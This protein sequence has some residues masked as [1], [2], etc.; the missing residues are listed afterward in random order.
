VFWFA[1]ALIGAGTGYLVATGAAADIGRAI[2][3]T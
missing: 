2:W 1:L 3:P